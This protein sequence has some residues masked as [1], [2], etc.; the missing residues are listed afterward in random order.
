M[1][2]WYIIR[3]WLAWVFYRPLITKMEKIVGEHDALLTLVEKAMAARRV[4]IDALRSCY[5]LF[6][7]VVKVTTRSKSGSKVTV[8][9]METARLL[10]KNQAMLQLNRLSLEMSEMSNFRHYLLMVKDHPNDKTQHNAHPYG[11]YYFSR[12]KLFEDIQRTMLGIYCRLEYS[13]PVEKLLIYMGTDIYE[14][15]DIV[16]EG[17]YPIINNEN[18]FIVFSDAKSEEPKVSLNLF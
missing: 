6:S 7:P 4:Q 1:R 14:K 17:A 10:I 16:V 11:E 2:K 3:Y 5:A 18:P 9:R 8:S 15:L 13:L 12:V